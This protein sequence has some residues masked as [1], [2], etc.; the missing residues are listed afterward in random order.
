MKY[1]PTPRKFPFLTS[2]SFLFERPKALTMGVFLGIFPLLTMILS[3]LITSTTINY[4]EPDFKLISEKGIEVEGTIE[5]KDIVTNITINDENPIIISYLYEV[6]GVQKRDSIQT[7]SL[8][9][10]RDWKVG[11]K[12]KVKHYQGDSIIP[13]A[14]PVN[15]YYW[16]FIFMPLPFS[17]VGFSFLGWAI[18][19][20]LKK[21]NLYKNGE[22]RIG[23]IVSMA[24]MND[25][26]TFFPYNRFKICYAFESHKGETLYGDSISSDLAF[27]NE[28]RKGDEVSLFVSPNNERVNCVVD[29]RIIRK[30]IG[31]DFIKL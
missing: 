30:A 6:N 18:A 24:P 31:I 3:L 29:E 25:Y 11:D 17:I 5:K 12:V 21:R 20:S 16:E 15:F 7:I 26:G 22:L 1:L 28:K 13:K 27:L 2:I 23:K 8:L 14:E 4:E 19:G 10:V 9:N